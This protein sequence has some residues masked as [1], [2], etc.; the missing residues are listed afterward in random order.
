[1][2]PAPGQPPVVVVHKRG[3]G[4]GCFAIGCIVALILVIVAIA[5]VAGIGYFTYTGVSKMT[6]DQAA[7]IPSFDG[8]DAM[9]EEATNKVNAFQKAAEGNQAARLELTADEINTL[10]SHNPDYAHSSYKVFVTLKGD[11]A[12]VD[13]SM[14]TSA[15]PVSVFPGR[16]INAEAELVPSF[17]ATSKNLNIILRRMKVGGNPMAQEQLAPIQMEMNPLLNVQLKRS[18]DADAIL[19]HA[20]SVAIQDNK[21][22]IQTQ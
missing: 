2:I 8:G 4:M 3:G 15:L 22:V 17:D 20:T 1:M 18:S 5:V 14:P 13:V 11:A 16:Y 7:A 19:Q 9:Y 10:I 21:L 12:T 6:S